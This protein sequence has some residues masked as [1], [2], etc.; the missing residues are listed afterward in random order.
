MYV[1]VYVFNWK[2]GME[3]NMGLQGKVKGCPVK[4]EFQINNK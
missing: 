2:C 1:N 4:C 3:G